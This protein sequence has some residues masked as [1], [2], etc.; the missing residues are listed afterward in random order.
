MDV[1]SEVDKKWFPSRIEQISGISKN[2]LCITRMAKKWDNWI[3]VADSMK[4]LSPKSPN[5]NILR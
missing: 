2:S 1:Y 5:T 4:G 3:D